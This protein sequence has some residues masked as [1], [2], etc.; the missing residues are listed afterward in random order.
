V[1]IADVVM[2]S[3]DAKLQPANIARL[4]GDEFVVVL[5]GVGC[6]EVASNVASRITEALG[7]PIEGAGHQFVVTPS[8]GIAMYP[9]DGASSDELLMNADAA[10]YRAKLAGRNTHSFYSGNM[11]VEALKRLSLENELRQAIDDGQFELYFQ[12]KVDIA[13]WSVVGAEALLRWHHESRGWIS[14]GEFIPVAEDSGLILPLGKWVLEQ[15]CRQVALWQK[16]G[17]DSISMAVNISSQQMHANDLVQVVERALADSGVA[18]GLLEFEITESFLMQDTK[19]TVNQLK[20]LRDIGIRISIDDFGTGYSS[21]SYLKRFPIDTL[22][23]DRS[24]VSDLHEDSDDAAICAAILAMSRKLGLAV[25][26]EG[27][28]LQEQLEFLKQHACEQIQG[29]L[30]SKPLPADA[31][32]ALVRAHSGMSAQAAE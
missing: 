16:A 18:P 9:R 29:Y 21:L 13:S 25:V 15:A 11:Q 31:F 5:R 14:P 6:E 32:E 2:P 3:D 17:L 8:I 1:R 24:F 12:P 20:A 26:A 7:A 4:G 23:I 22:K 19:A 27:V 30:F 28:E 10:M